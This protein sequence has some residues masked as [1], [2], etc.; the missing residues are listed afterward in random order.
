MNGK[1][2]RVAEQGPARPGLIR[3]FATNY[4]ARHRHPGN[5]ACH[6]VGLPVTFVVPWIIGPLYGWPWAAGTFFCGYALQFIGHAIEGND[7]GEIVLLKK[8]LGWPYREFG[9]DRTRRSGSA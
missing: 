2:F 4:A 6:V 8:C 3:R 1:A 9:P 5:I 7:A